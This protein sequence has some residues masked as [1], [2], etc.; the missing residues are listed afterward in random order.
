MPPT[1]YPGAIDAFVN[2]DGATDNLDDPPHDSQHSDA[3]D[4]IEAVETELG[5]NPRGSFAD[6][7][8]RLDDLALRGALGYAEVTA[9]QS[10]ITTLT[11][12]TGL[13]VAVNVAAGRRIRITGHAQISQ[14]ASGTETIATVLYVREG[15]TTLG[16]AAS[17]IDDFSGSRSQTHEGSIVLESPSEG[18]HTY[19]LSLETTIGAGSSGIN[20]ANDNPA[21]IL[22][23]D[24][25]PA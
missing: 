2:P 23:E 3:N 19:K 1:S 6:V 14:S 17:D 8:A 5:I 15:S 20:A 4:A 18:V 12:L 24:I 25:G 7:R 11:D 13:S 9:N 21:F 10:G 16:R 22:V